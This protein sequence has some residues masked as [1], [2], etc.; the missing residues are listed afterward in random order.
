[1]RGGGAR[2]NS[3]KLLRRVEDEH[4]IEKCAR[5]L[6]EHGTGE[7]ARPLGTQQTITEETF[8]KVVGDLGS[9][10]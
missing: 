8:G 7:R 1:V 3:G 5:A 9:A 10:L 2:T 6:A 4:I